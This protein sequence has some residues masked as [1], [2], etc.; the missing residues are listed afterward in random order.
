MFAGLINQAKAAASGIVLK[1]L[2]RASVAIPF[3][4]AFG[5]ALAAT[6]VM[7]VERFGHLLAYWFMAG[8]LA[9]LGIIAAI[10]VSVREH[11][12]EIA[13]HKAKATDTQEVVNDATAQALTQAPIALLGALLTIPGG[14]VGALNAARVLGRNWPLAFLLV[15]IGGLFWP[16]GKPAKADEV[17]EANRQAWP[18]GFHA[19]ALH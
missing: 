13:E 8:G 19:A 4:I 2:A 7:L 16:V 12:E 1:Y 17:E 18:N 5:F 3:V 14:A 15:L 11:E 6:T 10:V 9:V